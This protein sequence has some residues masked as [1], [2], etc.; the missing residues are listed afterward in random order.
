MQEKKTLATG[1]TVQGSA[2]EFVAYYQLEIQHQ[3]DTM[4]EL[5]Q[6]L[7]KDPQNRPLLEEI[8]RASQAISDLAMVYGFEGVEVIADRIER[9]VK[10]LAKEDVSEEFLLR[11]GEA[12]GAIEKAMI[13]IDERRERQIIRDLSRQAFD[14]DSFS[15]VEPASEIYSNDEKT[16]EDEFN[17][18]IKED[19][20][21]ISI[22]SDVD[23]EL[24]EIE[25]RPVLPSEKEK[26]D[27]APDF[28]P[29]DSSELNFEFQTGEEKMFS[30][31]ESASG[32]DVLEIDFQKIRESADKKKEGL[33]HKIS[34]LFG[35]KSEKQEVLEQS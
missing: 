14:S 25:N 30:A 34:R 4:R 18:D 22:L 5:V 24:Y 31:D 11:L 32:E 33:F 17:F 20:K 12:I 19:E 13:L 21:L 26:A 1:E 2:K 15:Y 23:D 10:K 8:H 3:V 27:P 6:Q 28:E 16:Q 35:G 9:A 7:R 29:V